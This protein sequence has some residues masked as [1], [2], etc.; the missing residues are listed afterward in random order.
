VTAI[1]LNN[2]IEIHRQ[3]FE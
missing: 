1:N 2:F 3:G